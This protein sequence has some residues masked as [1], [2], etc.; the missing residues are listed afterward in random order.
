[1]SPELMTLLLFGSMLLG[2][3]MGIPL[4]FVLGGVAM[5]FTYLLWGQAAVHMVAVN[6]S[7]LQMSFLLVCAPLFLFMGVVLEKSGIADDM[8]DMMYQWIGP[9]KGGL[10]MGVVLICTI[11]AAMTGISAVA[12]ITMGII[13]LP[14]MLNRNYHKS[15]AL[16]SIMAGGALGILIP[17]SLMMI[18][19]GFMARVSVGQL[20]IGGIFPGLVL[21]SL[22]LLYIGIR[23]NF[24]R[25]L[26]P[27]VLPE[28]RVSVAERLVLLKALIPPILLVFGVLGSIFLGICSP[29]EAAAVGA[30]GSLLCAAVKRRLSWKVITEASMTT[31]RITTMALWIT[32]GAQCFTATY[33]ALG[34]QELV[35]N[36]IVSLEMNR[37]VVLILIQVSFFLLGMIMD[38]IG[39]IL[40]TTPIYV[41]IITYLGFDPIWFGVLFTVNMEMAYITPPFG[42]NLFY[43][44]GIV[45]DGVTM[46]D[47]YR[48]I[49][50]FVLL[51]AIGLALVMIFPQL[52]LWLPS[53][54]IK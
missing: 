28:E 52:A 27:P 8:F 12:T 9:L 2:L 48:S 37:W 43:M 14:A 40:L 10:A 5:I 17:P 54:M 34:G 3:A 22:F 38:P 11:F 24:Q 31:L 49:I 35:R 39:I 36:L 44:K 33:A 30:F 46:G 23:C 41:P 13:A 50:P 20:F 26:G 32:I 25:H 1:M 16:G 29:T 6:F 4:S 19:Y 21:S 51:Q 42:F 7:G 53:L 15:I 18:L 47:I 45:P